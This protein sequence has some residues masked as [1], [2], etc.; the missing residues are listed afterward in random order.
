MLLVKIFLI[1]NSKT[2]KIFLD[3][4]VLQNASQQYKKYILREI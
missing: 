4:H 2:K 1:H 3:K